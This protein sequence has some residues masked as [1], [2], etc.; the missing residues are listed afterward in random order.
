MSGTGNATPIGMRRLPLVVIF[1]AWWFAPLRGAT[2]EQ[3]SFAELAQKSTAIVRA[4]VV[5]SYADF[6]G[7]EIFTHWKLEVEEQWKGLAAA[8][9]M[10]PGGSVRGYRQG[11]AGAPQLSVGKE[12]VLFLWT[13]KS[14]A[15]YL[16]GWGQGVFELSE[17]K[18]GKLMATRAAASETVVE[19]GTW[20]PVKD[21]GLRIEY[22]DL[23]SQISAVAGKGARR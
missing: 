1:L 6:R 9:V 15:T 16:T 4:R 12:Y 17:D 13:S 11:V 10:D 7:A 19:H 14:G 21:A 22:S 2:L 23:A 3:L 8:E 20:R 18:A 5:D